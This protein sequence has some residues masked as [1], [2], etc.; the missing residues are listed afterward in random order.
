MYG[1]ARLRQ[2]QRLS[3]SLQRLHLKKATNGR[4]EAM[5]PHLLRWL[6]TTRPS[7]LGRDYLVLIS[8]HLG[9]TP[10]AYILSP[11][12]PQISPDQTNLIPHIYSEKKDAKYP[13][14]ICLCLYHPKY[15]EWRNNMSLAATFVPWIDLWLYFFEDWLVTGEW[16]GGGEHPN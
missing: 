8:Y 4:C 2:Q 16:R 1:K 12:L 15:G 11:N 13:N 3:I 6:Y 9:N 10:T 5:C 7:A 14:A